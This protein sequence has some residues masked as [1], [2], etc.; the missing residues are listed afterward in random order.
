MEKIIPIISQI[1]TIDWPAVATAIASVCVA[2]TAS[3]ALHTWKDQIRAQQQISFLDALVDEVHTFIQAMNAPIEAL[4]YSKI[5]IQAYADIPFHP[6]R[7]DNDPEGVIQYINE[8]GKDDQSQLFDHLR[9]AAP[10]KNKL[11][12]LATKGQ[13]IGFKN[14]DRCYAAC[15]NLSLTLGQIEGFASMIGNSNLNWNN[16]DVKKALSAVMAVDAETIR[17]RHQTEHVAFLDFVKDAYRA[18]YK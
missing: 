14:Y 3:R 11:L 1:N 4:R 17:T 6:S 13:V 16:P 18:I 7:K 12:S 10:S 2:I 9:N 5:G 15:Y 8:H